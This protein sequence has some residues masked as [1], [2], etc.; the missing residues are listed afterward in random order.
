MREMVGLGL[1]TFTKRETEEWEIQ[2]QHLR[3]R[4]VFYI[5]GS[6]KDF[7]DYGSP[8][9]VETAGPSGGLILI[10]RAW[11]ALTYADCF[12][13]EREALMPPPRAIDMTC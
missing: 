5:D 7:Y 10:T 6:A 4:R 12:A 13:T 9:V 11:P 8:A 3:G 2:R 1:L